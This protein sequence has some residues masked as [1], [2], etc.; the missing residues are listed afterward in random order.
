MRLAEQ[1]AQNAYAPYSHYAVG[2]ALLGKS[3]RVYCGC[4]VEN[5]AYSPSICAER[6]AVGCAVASGETRFAAIAVWGKNDCTPCG[7]CRQTLA[8]FCDADFP[9][10]TKEQGEI[11]TR[12]LDELLP[13]SFGR[14]QL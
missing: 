10:Y 2:A 7:V 12:R 4:N 8:E 9:V 13:A 5:A 3:G 6:V 1:S 14:S 11:V